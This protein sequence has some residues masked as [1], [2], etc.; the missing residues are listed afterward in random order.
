[1]IEFN[2]AADKHRRGRDALDVLQPALRRRPALRLPPR[3][4][5]APPLPPAA[6]ERVLL[7]RDLRAPRR[8][9][10]GRRARTQAARL[11]S[12]LD[13]WILARLQQLIAEVTAALDDYDVY[14][15]TTPVEE[16]LDDLSNWYVRRSRRRFWKVEADADKQ[17]AY[18]TLYEVLVTLTKLLAPF[19]PFVTEEMYQNLV[20]S[21]DPTAPLSVHHCAW[22]VVDRGACADEA[23]V[24]EMAAVRAVV[25]LG[26][27]VR[28]AAN[29]KV[30][31]PLGR[32]VVVAAAGAARPAAAPRAR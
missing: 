13:R 17:A 14:K 15:A 23:L 27:A 9:D 4:R 30:R 10:A 3:R 31:Q 12:E 29:L 25:A 19:M 24:A 28:A 2:E 11:Q 6:V 7:L 21:V 32:V 18:A 1:M 20:R 26:H 8:V 22:P 5:D 16:F